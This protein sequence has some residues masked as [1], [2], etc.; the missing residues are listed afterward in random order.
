MLS[1]YRVYNTISNWIQGPALY[2][3]MYAMIEN[4]G[5]APNRSGNA[6]NIEHMEQ[7]KT[8]LM[9]NPLDKG[10]SVHSYSKDGIGTQQILSDREG[11][12]FLGISTWYQFVMLSIDIWLIC[13]AD[14][15]EV[16]YP[17]PAGSS[18]SNKVE[19]RGSL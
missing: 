1:I 3:E 5:V 11:S 19:F 14:L 12:G 6:P 9:L 8:Y 17:P 7:N 16:C 2:N 13:P 10:L 4:L 15:V 18:T